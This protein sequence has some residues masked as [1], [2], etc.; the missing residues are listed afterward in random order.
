MPTSGKAAGEGKYVKMFADVKYFTT[1]AAVSVWSLHDVAKFV[2]KTSKASK[3][4]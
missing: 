4:N 3:A 1:P 2:I